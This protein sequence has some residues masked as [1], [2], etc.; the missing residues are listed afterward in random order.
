LPLTRHLPGLCGARGDHSRLRARLLASL[1]RSDECAITFL[2]TVQAE[3]TAASL[4]LADRALHRLARDE[5]EGPYEVKVEPA[6]EPR[7]AIVRLAADAD[8]VLMGMPFVRG[9]S[10]ALGPVALAVAAE[11]ETP[12]ILIGSRRPG[13]RRRVRGPG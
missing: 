9:P 4:R 13:P 2:R 11:T 8:L 7:T 3:T 1:T 10:R 12:L 5:L 6:A